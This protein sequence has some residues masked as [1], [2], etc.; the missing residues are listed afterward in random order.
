MT[1]RKRNEEQIKIMLRNKVI[2]SKEST[3]FLRM[4]LDSSLNWEEHIEQGK[5]WGEIGKPKK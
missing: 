2:S 1:F 3:Q 4:T 5:N